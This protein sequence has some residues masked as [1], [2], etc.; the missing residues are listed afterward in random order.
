M[1]EL[2]ARLNT[3]TFRLSVGSG[4]IP[5]I[6]TQDIAAALGMVRNRFGADAL[7]FLHC[8]GMIDE[9]R[10]QVDMLNRLRDECERQNDE[11]VNRELSYLLNSGRRRTLERLRDFNAGKSKLWPQFDAANFGRYASLVASVMG[12]VKKGA[13]CSPCKG[14]GMINICRDTE[15]RLMRMVEGAPLSGMCRSCSGTGTHP[16][17]QRARAA[18]MKISQPVFQRTWATPYAWLLSDFLAAAAEAN[19]EFRS[20]LGRKAA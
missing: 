13:L 5:D 18:R 17:P 4:G 7:A 14:S 12:E 20:A 1:S 11:S 15:D 9:T 6:T 8:P 16:D 10:F 3:P 19:S 2:L